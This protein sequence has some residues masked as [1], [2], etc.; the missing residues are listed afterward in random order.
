MGVDITYNFQ[1]I[2]P[3][4]VSSISKNSVEQRSYKYENKPAP[5]G[6]GCM[7]SLPDKTP[8]TGKIHPTGKIILTFEPI[9][10]L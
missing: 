8:P 7:Q 3:A 1:E 10:Q 5:Q 4:L 9:M 2:F 6:A